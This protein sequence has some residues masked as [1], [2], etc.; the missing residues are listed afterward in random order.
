MVALY[1][2]L[3]KTKKVVSFIYRR[4]TRWLFYGIYN[5]FIAQDPRFLFS[6]I[7][8]QR[9][10]WST[11]IPHSTGLVIGSS[12]E[13]GEN[14]MIYQNVTFGGR[15][16]EYETKHPTVGDNVVIYSGA[17]IL[18]DITI[19]DGAVVAANSVVLD[20]VPEGVVVAGAPAKIVK[21]A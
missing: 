18:G 17:V 12:T 8:H 11:R 20:D 21:Q 9:L 2:K 6:C 14:V 16:I 5:S 7:A 15:G 1:N 13:L 10:P 3:Y 4:L 19:G